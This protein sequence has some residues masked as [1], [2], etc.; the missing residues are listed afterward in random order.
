MKSAA[1]TLAVLAAVGL[2]LAALVRSGHDRV[3]RTITVSGT[4]TV[5]GVP[6]RAEFSF[7]V[8]TQDA[9]AKAASEANAATMTKVIA[10]LTDNNVPEAAIQTTGVS[11]SQ[12]TNPTG[13]KVI[14]FEASNSVTVDLAVGDS[15]PIVDAVVAA[16]ANNVGGP[17]FTATDQAQLYRKA[18]AAAVADA[19]G[20]AETIAEAVGQKLHRVRTVSELSS[21][22]TPYGLSVAKADSSVTTPVEP[23]NIKV[24]ADITATFDLG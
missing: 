13:T 22:P 14:G 17:T 6:D 15:G 20:R 8:T 3:G 2:G 16:G 1:I 9:T 10:A 19:R 23:G 12:R 4:G 21:A 24:E 5:S 11:L 18:L 7:G